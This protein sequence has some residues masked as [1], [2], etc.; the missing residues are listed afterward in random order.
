[1]RAPALTL[2]FH[3][4][5]LLMR[6]GLILNSD[7]PKYHITVELLILGD[8]FLDDTSLRRDLLCQIVVKNLRIVAQ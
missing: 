7:T 8:D 4:P 5:A 1:M 2:T 6:S 3:N